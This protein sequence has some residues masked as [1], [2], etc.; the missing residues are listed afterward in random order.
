M[1]PSHHSALRCGRLFCFGLGFTGARFARALRAEGWQVSGTSRDEIMLNRLRKD[2]ITG[3]S[4]EAAAIPRGTSHMLSTIPPGA[5]GDPVLL[6]YRE[7]IAAAKGLAWIGYLSTTGVYGD[8]GGEMVNEHDMP[9]PGNVRSRRRRAAEEAWRGFGRRHGVAVQIFR[10]AGIY[11]PGRSALDAVR[12]GTAKRIDKPEHLFSRIHVDDIVATLMASM[13]YPRAGAVYNV[14]D[15]EAAAPADVTLHACKL[16]GIEPPPM[17]PFDADAMS[18]MA[19]SFWAENRR[20][21]NAL[22][23]HELG[24]TLRYPDYRA[25]LKAILVEEEAK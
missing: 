7:A 6:D 16:L 14:C 19:R 3:G 24:V 9:S 4:L 21:S 1:T 23:K 12:A 10:L 5:M 11:G 2:G 15:D 18:P 8:R 25:G 22:I 17:E 13:A 20:V